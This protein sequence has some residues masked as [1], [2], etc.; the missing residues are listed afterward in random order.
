M[1]SSV[2]EMKESD[3]KFVV[4]Y[5]VDADPEWRSFLEVLDAH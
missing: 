3:I 2:R 1:S 5:F 4:D